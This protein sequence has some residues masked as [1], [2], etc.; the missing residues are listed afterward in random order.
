MSSRAQMAEHLSMSPSSPTKTFVLEVHPQGDPV[1]FLESFMEQGRLVATDDAYLFRLQTADGDFWVDQLDGR[2]WSF[3]TDMPTGVAAAYLNKQVSARR[4]LDWLWLPSE[5]LREPWPGAQ[6]RKTRVRFDGSKLL[7]D[8]SSEMD[9]LKLQASG[10]GAALLDEYLHAKG[11]RSAAAYDAVEVVVADDEFGTV[12][13]GVNRKGRFAV[14]GTSPELHF[15]FVQNIVD[16]YRSLVLLCERK[17]ISW[18]PLDGP[19]NDIGAQLKGGPIGIRFSR[20]IPDLEAFVEELFSSRDPFRLWGTPRLS[21]SSDIAEVEAVDL[22]V[23][24]QLSFD[25]GEQWMRVYLNS[26]GCGNT[27][28]RLVSNLQYRFDAAL[29]FTDPELQAALMASPIG[30]S[31]AARA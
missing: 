31:T 9:D 30:P 19:G 28:A 21:A 8:S 3:H 11:L 4:D 26:G 14:S 18:T 24:E 5:H 22:H 13:E 16:R 29:S 17:S 23:G 20:S 1:A 15:Q 25:I 12:R 27:I 2:F 7:R 6:R 10:G